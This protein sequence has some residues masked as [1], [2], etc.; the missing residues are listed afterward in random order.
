VLFSA[1]C[2]GAT[3]WQQ[4]FPGPPPPQPDTPRIRPALLVVINGFLVL[5]ALSAFVS[6]WFGR[7]GGD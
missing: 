6:I 7:T 1:F 4:V 3:I 5:V 2:F